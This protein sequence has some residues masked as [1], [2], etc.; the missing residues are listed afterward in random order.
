MLR[1][2]SGKDYA[3]ADTIGARKQQ[4]DSCKF[5]LINGD[6]ELL[7]VLADGMGGHAAGEVASQVAV[8]G[9]VKSFL[10][11]APLSIPGR[12][13]TALTAAN[14]ELAEA[15]RTSPGCEGMGCTL[16]AMHVSE[17][18]IYWISVGDSPLFLVRGRSIHQINEDHSMA[19]EI[20]LGVREGRLTKQ[21]A[22][23]HPSR[24]ALRSAL[25]G[26]EVPELIDNPTVP[27]Q[28]RNNDTL[29]LASDGLQTL[30]N[31]QIAKIV[32]GSAS[33]GEVARHLIDQVDS[34][35]RNR[36][37]NATVQVIKLR[38]NKKK[39]LATK[40]G[41]YW[42]SIL[43]G[44][45][46]SI[47][48]GGLLLIKSSIIDH[49]RLN[50]WKNGFTTF[51]ASIFQSAKEPLSDAEEIYQ[52]VN[53]GPSVAS[54]PKTAPPEA[55]ST[56]PEGEEPIPASKS[57]I[58][59]GIEVSKNPVQNL[60]PASHKTIEA[61]EAKKGSEADVESNP[62]SKIVPNKAVDNAEIFIKNDHDPEGL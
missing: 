62:V 40:S 3:A 47:I 1:L 32:N 53:S 49:K 14:A 17:A 51:S 18:G 8:L 31:I 38:S 50:N 37:D 59:K 54:V 52:S 30:T 16:V 15:I 21:E 39:I 43:I 58:S 22:A 7:A 45:L 28:W 44:C 48:F 13:A 36:Q 55:Q 24:N 6:S 11:Q 61:G 4:E 5:A 19:P 26:D 33:A 9:F 27:L 10:S 2:I 20:D 46:L 60:P 23:S 57:H 12:L 29:I 35:K 34:A 56:G 41:V 25:L 42:L